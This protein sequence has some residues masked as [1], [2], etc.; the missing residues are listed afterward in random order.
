M[1]AFSP[2]KTGRNTDLWTISRNP[3]YNGTILLNN[4]TSLHSLRRQRPGVIFAEDNYN[5]TT[6]IQSLSGGLQW[7]KRVMTHLTNAVDINCGNNT[8]GDGWSLVQPL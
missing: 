4:G 3:L 7:P 5:N 2:D 8:W 1:G 6:N